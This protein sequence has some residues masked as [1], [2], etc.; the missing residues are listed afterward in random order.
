ML[1]ICR[2]YN[3]EVYH[4]RRRKQ[5]ELDTAANRDIIKLYSLGCVAEEG[6]ACWHD[7]SSG[8]HTK[9]KLKSKAI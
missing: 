7:S 9:G 2:P 3:Y 1:K 8:G 6:A 4:H 5:V